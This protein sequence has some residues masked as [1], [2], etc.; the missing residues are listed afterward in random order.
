MKNIKPGRGPSGLNAMGSRFGI[1]FAI[2]WTI[3]A[4]SMGAPIFFAGFG[5]IFIIMSIVQ[6]VYHYKNATGKNRYSEFE[7]T[8]EGE[9]ADPLN[10]YVR[11]R[12]GDT[13]ADGTPR[14]TSSGENRFC[15]YCGAKTDEDFEYCPK[16]GKK[17]PF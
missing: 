1:V 13:Y 8:D 4:V 16:C 5:V 9:E 3:A 2:F 6:F 10:E 11:Q 12:Y 17:L 14:E 15:P 7:I